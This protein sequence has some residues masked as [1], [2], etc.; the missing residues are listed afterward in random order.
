MPDSQANYSHNR[1]GTAVRTFRPFGRVPHPFEAAPGFLSCGSLLPHCALLQFGGSA[2][3]A[4]GSID[5]T[6]P[7][8]DLQPFGWIGQLLKLR[9][10]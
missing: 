3:P 7:Q 2:V 4:R 8:Y 1:P 10:I 6:K 9:A 5:F